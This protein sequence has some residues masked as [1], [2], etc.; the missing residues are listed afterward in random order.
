MVYLLHYNHLKDH[1]L[2]H[3]LNQVEVVEGIELSDLKVKDLISHQN[4][5][6]FPGHGL[7]FFRKG[8][9][10]IYIGKCSSMSFIERIPSHFDIRVNAYKNSLLRCICQKK[11]EKEVNEANLLEAARYC[12]KEYN[13]VLIN[14]V[15]TDRINKLEGLLRHSCSPLNKPASLK[16]YDLSKKLK[17]F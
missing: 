8:K 15:E 2:A 11:F 10:I 9:R 13:L 17:E 1:D 12:V 5:T 4:E 6:I 16:N 3:L 7:Y 14:F